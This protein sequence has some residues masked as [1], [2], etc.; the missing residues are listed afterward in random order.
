MIWIILS[1]AVILYFGGKILIPAKETSLNL[2]K[3]IILCT[4]GGVK[5]FV[6]CNIKDCRTAFEQFGP[7][8]YCL[9][10]CL[11]LYSCLRACPREAIGKDLKI[12]P[13]L[14]D[15][16]GICIEAC[17]LGLVV[18]NENSKNIYTACNTALGPEESDSSCAKSC[19]KCYI[20]FEACS[21]AAIY[22]D[23]RG[24]PHIDPEKCDNCLACVKKCPTG[25]IRKI[26]D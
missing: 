26:Y 20:C 2:K 10:G 1:A 17:P 23:Q 15:G 8:G 22:I 6:Y 24:I 18:L 13:E 4:N 14:C 19:I 3:P 21:Q 7:N 25:V 5:K 11:G 16:C 12:D 9:Q